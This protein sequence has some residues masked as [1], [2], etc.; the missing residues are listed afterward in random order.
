MEAPA[1]SACIRP[2]LRPSRNKYCTSFAT[3]YVDVLSDYCLKFQATRSQFIYVGGP[4]P[5]CAQAVDVSD[6][7]NTA[8]GLSCQIR[9]IRAV[10]T[11]VL[12]EYVSWYLDHCQLLTVNT[13]SVL[14]F[15]RGSAIAVDM[16]VVILTW[17]KT[18]GHWRRLR[19]LNISFS[20]T[21]ILIRDGRDS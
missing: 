15:T 21:D 14:F 1:H 13:L 8:Y 4:I 18:F 10:L 11:C 9:Q 5:A 6:R 20:V 16:A 2:R 19:Q 7:T 12:Q 3:V 17:I